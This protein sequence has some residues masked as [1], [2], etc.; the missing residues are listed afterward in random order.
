MHVCVFLGSQHG[1]DPKYTDLARRVGQVLAMRGM[2][3]VYGGGCVGLMGELARSAIKSG[4]NVIGV[5][6]HGLAAIEVAY[7]DITELITVDTLEERKTAMFVRSDA[8]IAL[9]GGVGTLDE[10]FTVMS[11]NILKY[12]KKPMGVLNFEGFFDPLL[13]MLS[14]QRE[15]HFIPQVKTNDLIVAEDIDTLLDELAAIDEILRLI[16]Q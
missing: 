13:K 11:W 9:P 10:L 3:L 7:N 2:T 1:K 4:G 15:E 5:I 8:F 12:H 14:M 6:T 16:E